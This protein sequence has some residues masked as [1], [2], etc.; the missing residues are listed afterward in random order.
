M[1]PFPA[2]ALLLRRPAASRTSGKFHAQARN[3][4]LSELYNAVGLQAAVMHDH[5]PVDP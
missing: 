5:V 1:C 2:L 3:M 4:V